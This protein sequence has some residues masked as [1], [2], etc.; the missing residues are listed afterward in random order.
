MG[1]EQEPFLADG[2]MRCAR[3]LGCLH[4]RIVGV[5]GRQPTSG[6]P[7]EKMQRP[8]KGF[9]NA[10]EE[11]H[12]Q[13]CS[14]AYGRPL[15]TCLRCSRGSISR[16]LLLALLCSVLS[17]ASCF[18]QQAALRWLRPAITFARTKPVIT[19]AGAQMLAISQSLL[20]PC[21]FSTLASASKIPQQHAWLFGSL[22]ALQASCQTTC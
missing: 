2:S 10:A 20:L 3:T 1:K 14:P 22:V 16:R 12:S 13:V 11:Y 17:S 5:K 9:R 6:A 21:L 4:A 8:C 18:M 7:Q 15:G 19:A